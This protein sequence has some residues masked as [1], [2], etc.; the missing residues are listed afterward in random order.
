MKIKKRVILD[1]IIMTNIFKSTIP[2]KNQIHEQKNIGDQLTKFF[3]QS[4]EF[5]YWLQNFLIKL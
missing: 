3:I 5:F 1:N 2:I 4:H